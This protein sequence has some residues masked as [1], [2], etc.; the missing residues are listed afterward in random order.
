MVL[1]ILAAIA[2]VVGI[3]WIELEVTDL[4]VTSYCDVDGYVAKTYRSFSD[5]GAAV[6][7]EMKELG[8]SC[9]C[10][11]TDGVFAVIT[12]AAKWLLK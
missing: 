1:G 4:E 11:R 3:I 2:A 6:E 10:S 12:P 9:G 8:V 5:C 7:E